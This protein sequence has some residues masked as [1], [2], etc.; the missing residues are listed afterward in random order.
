MLWGH[1]DKMLSPVARILLIGSK[2][3]EYLRMSEM[4]DSGQAMP[5]QLFWCDQLDLATAELNSGRYDLILLDCI[6]DPEQAL[7]L[8]RSLTAQDAPLPIVAITEVVDGAL[9]QQVLQTGASDYLVRDNCDSYV[10]ERCI[11]HTLEKHEAN[12]KLKQLNLYDPLTGAPN[13]ILFKQNMKQAIEC[14]KEQSQP[15]ALL[16]VNMDGFKKINE[17]YGSEAGDHLVST[18]AKRL[19][20]CVRK[21]DSVA[22]IGA[23]EFTIIL[24]DC[25][26]R[27]N[28]AQV[29]QKIIDVLAVPFDI[30]DTP[31]ILSCSIGI[32]LYPEDGE[33][34][35][36]LLH[37][38]N[39]AM[40]EAKNKRCLLYTSP[41]PRDS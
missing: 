22:R 36:G 40:K 38:A 23:D 29:A 41:S 3:A 19:S 21:S 32:T 4:L 20:K 27:E 34:V 9:V 18:M 35:D 5:F 8:I 6:D 33:T 2:H 24:E 13:R 10:L 1:G 15:L 28:V 37:R 30:D 14:V 31:L 25:G 16:L 17:S 12:T 26:H 39:M 7:Q 11:S